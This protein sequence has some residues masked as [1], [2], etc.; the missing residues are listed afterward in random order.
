MFISH[1]FFHLVPLLHFP[2]SVSF[3]Y[4][5]TKVPLWSLY[6]D[7]YITIFNT[8]YFCLMWF[9]RKLFLSFFLSQDEHM[10]LF[11][12]NMNLMI[13][14]ELFIK[15]LLLLTTILSDDGSFTPSLLPSQ[16]HN[17]VFC[18]SRVAFTSL[19]YTSS[20][21]CFY[22]NL[23]TSFL[24]QE[25]DQALENTNQIIFSVKILPMFSHYNT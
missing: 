4:Q 10:A 25:Q 18:S 13:I 7:S 24:T 21:P 3:S 14:I 23:P 16:S 12:I 17:I 20:F 8:C 2:L 19:P 11:L 6:E 22:W 9:R 15:N 1:T 5:F